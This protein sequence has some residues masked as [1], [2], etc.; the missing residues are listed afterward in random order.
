MKHCEEESLMGYVLRGLLISLL[1]LSVCYIKRDPVIIH[2]FNSSKLMSKYS[3]KDGTINPINSWFVKNNN[4]C[5][6]GASFINMV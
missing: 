1:M 6:P 5:K 2:P 3:P 4:P